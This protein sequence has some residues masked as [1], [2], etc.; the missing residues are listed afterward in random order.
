M[1][2]FEYI[3]SSSTGEAIIKK[4]LLRNSD[5]LGGGTNLVDLM[6][7]NI[8]TPSSLIDVTA[9]PHDEIK[10]HGNEV[11]I[12]ALENNSKTANHPLIRTRYPLLSKAI[13]SGATTQI[14]NMATNGGNLLQKTRCAYYT[15]LNMPCNKRVPGS[16]CSA[17]HGHNREH[18]IFGA[19]EHCVCT[20]PS[21]MCVALMALDARIKIRSTPRMTRTLAVDDFFRLPGN[22]PYLDN[23]LKKNELIEAIILPKSD[24]SKNYYYLKIRD[25]ASYAFALV[26][27]AAGMNLNGDKIKNIAIA[28]GGVAHKPWRARLAES[29]LKGKIASASNF[30]RAADMELKS[31]KPLEHNAFKIELARQAI[32]RALKQAAGEKV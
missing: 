3:K 18:A 15:D 29:W 22:T 2:N 11:L 12:G 24:F 6:K 31:A 25:R 14:R 8:A 13:L 32:V 9:L 17:L 26:S 28:M 10:D 21:D 27:V 30:E 4:V 16:G 20:H 19:S 23:N 1:N 7:N 5:Y